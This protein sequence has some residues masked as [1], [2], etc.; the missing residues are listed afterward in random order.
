MEYKVINGTEFNLTILK[1]M[2]EDEVL[3]LYSDKLSKNKMDEL[4][5]E[6]SFPKRK[7]K[8]KKS[9]EDK[10]DSGD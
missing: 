8:P 2:G 10:E 6:L 9:E 4:M 3:K 7:P 1:E 5:K